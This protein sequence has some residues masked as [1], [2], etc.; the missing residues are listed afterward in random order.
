MIEK[1]CMKCAFE[2]CTEPATGMACGRDLSRYNEKKG[3]PAPAWFCEKHARVVTNENNPEHI[4]DC[5]NCRCRFG[6]N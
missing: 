2:D 5:P 4:V 1:L 3:H 6:V